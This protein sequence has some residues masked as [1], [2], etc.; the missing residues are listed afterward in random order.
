MEDLHH[1]ITQSKYVEFEYLDLPYE[2]SKIICPF[3]PLLNI[4]EGKEYG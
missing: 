3:P 2:V 4:Q 1:Q